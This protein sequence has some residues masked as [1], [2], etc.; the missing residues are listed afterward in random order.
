MNSI[1]LKFENDLNSYFKNFLIQ[2]SNKHKIHTIL[3]EWKTFSENITDG[4]TTSSIEPIVIEKSK[5]VVTPTKTEDPNSLGSIFNVL[6]NLP[7]G[8]NESKSLYVEGTFKFP[9]KREIADK[10]FKLSGY[11]SQN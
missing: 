3:D 1:I 5:T 2:I 6:K 7:T 10:V 11:V 8:G 9:K 4:K